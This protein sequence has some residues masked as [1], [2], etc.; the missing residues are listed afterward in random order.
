MTIDTQRLRELAMAATTG[1]WLV[2]RYGT[3]LHEIYINISES[4]TETVI[5][6][7]PDG[8][9]VPSICSADAE[10]IAAA[11]PAAVLALLDEI[12]RS[13]GTIDIISAA[14]FAAEKELA[15]LRPIKA[16]ALNLAKVKGRHNSEIAMNKLLEALK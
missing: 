6:I 5:G 1:E 16:S 7:P 8:S 11:N 2:E 9:S 3:G 4:E 14:L 15:E 10:Y 12:D 13:R